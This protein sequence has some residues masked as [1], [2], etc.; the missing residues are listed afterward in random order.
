MARSSQEIDSETNSGSDGMDTDSEPQAEVILDCWDAIMTCETEVCDC[1]LFLLVYHFMQFISVRLLSRR[2]L[3][4][5][6]NVWKKDLIF[7]CMTNHCIKLTN[8]Y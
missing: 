5:I 1:N 7:Y 2:F 3:G 8:Q 6:K 4:L